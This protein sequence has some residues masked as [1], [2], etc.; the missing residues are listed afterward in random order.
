MT[1]LT[2]ENMTSMIKVSVPTDMVVESKVI[3]WLTS[4]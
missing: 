1:L 4:R 3:D 2:P